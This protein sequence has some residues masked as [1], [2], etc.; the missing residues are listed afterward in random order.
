[1]ST[2]SREHLLTRM[3]EEWPSLN[4]LLDSISEGEMDE[5]GVVDEWSLKEL[6]GHM[7]FWAEKAAH[8][9]RAVAEGRIDDIKLP[10]GQT[11]V[12]LW[13]A[14]AAARGKAM[15]VADLKAELARRHEEARKAL[16]EVAEAG[17]AVQL[18]GWSVGLR[19][20]EDTYRHYR[21]HAEQI[22]A[23]QRQLETTEA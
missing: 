1:M 10:G 7:I 16:E 14:E 3:D 8:D 6:L 21:E 9:L 20:A 13:N 17:L 22:R 12:D 11:N 15:S 4:A 5:P 2:E 23:W 18:G 19:F